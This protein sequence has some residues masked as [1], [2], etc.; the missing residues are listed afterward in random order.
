MPN[1]PS[2]ELTHRIGLPG[3]PAMRPRASSGASIGVPLFARAA[4][5][6]RPPIGHYDGGRARF[7]RGDTDPKGD[8]MNPGW[9]LGPLLALVGADDGRPR[10][11]VLTTDC[12]VEV[13]DQW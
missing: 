6:R 13:D 12:G 1:R 11:V 3:A 4:R 9:W 7:Q 2:A 5:V 8:A 10:P